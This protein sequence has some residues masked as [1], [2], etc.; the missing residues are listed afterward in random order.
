MRGAVWPPVVERVVAYAGWRQT[1]LWFGVCQLLIIAPFAAIFL[2]AAPDLSFASGQLPRGATAA[3]RV[4]GC[5]RNFVFALM[6]VGAVF[7]C[8]PMAMPQA[9][10]PALCSDLGYRASHGAAM[11]SVLLGSAFISRQFWGFVADRFGGL[12][13]ALIGS[14]LQIFTIV[15]I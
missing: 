13:T 4:L 8:M 3:K 2:R 15:V 14:I 11:V 12:R 6:A 7:C 1:M 10:L 9:H 5:P